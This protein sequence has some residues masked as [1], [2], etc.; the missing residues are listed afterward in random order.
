MTTH[1]ETL[2]WGRI[3]EA[4][5][6]QAGMLI[7]LQDNNPP[8]CTV[9][10][11]GNVPSEPFN[12]VENDA[13]AEVVKECFAKQ[14]FAHEHGIGNFAL[15]N[16]LLRFGA[17]KE[18]AAVATFCPLQTGIGRM[19]FLGFPLG[20]KRDKDRPHNVRGHV[21]PL[22]EYLVDRAKLSYFEKKL[23][24]TELYIR[25][26]GHDLA[27]NMQA[28][29]GQLNSMK[30]GKLTLKAM[31]EKSQ[32][33]LEEVRNIYGIAE[34]LDV[35]LDKS[36]SIETRQKVVIRDL[37]AQLCE[38]YQAEANE[39]NLRLE[40]S[41][42]RPNLYA[43][44]DA[45]ALRLCLVHLLVNA[46]K[47]SHDNTTV[48]LHG[49]YKSPDVLISVSN[50]GVGI[51]HG[52]EASKIWDFGYRSKL[53]KERHVNGSGIGLYTAKRIVVAHGG[54]IWHQQTG[55]ETVFVV[56]IPT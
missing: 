39:K 34:S 51:P 8:G 28:V 11:A 35:T 12:G 14:P 10:S 13:I 32:A 23:E 6:L 37:F 41:L 54:R 26:I 31:I 27:S 48:A 16:L 29:F 5:H 56:A 53:A 9:I 47:Y 25:E 15:A 3:L 36:Y 20:N 1:I 40:S 44:A 2:L 4:L 38:E 24:F 50:R 18:V 22:V 52:E 21:D 46:I 42:I 17:K 30:S 19:A 49:D 43:H 55:P 7:A 45:K 33:V